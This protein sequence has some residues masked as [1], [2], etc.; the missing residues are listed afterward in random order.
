[1]K[2]KCKTSILGEVVP[3]SLTLLIN[4]GGFGRIFYFKPSKLKGQNK[5]KKTSL[6]I[7]E[8]KN[9]KTNYSTTKND[10]SVEFSLSSSLVDKIKSFS[11]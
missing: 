4:R 1:M 9:H 8:K 5:R 11:Q 2:K 6:K 10:F 7:S 3:S